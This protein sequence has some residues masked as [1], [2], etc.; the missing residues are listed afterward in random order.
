MIVRIAIVVAIV[1]VLMIGW[2][3]ITASRRLRPSVAS[4]KVSPA[5]LG[6]ATIPDAILFSTPYCVPCSRIIA[7]IDGSGVDL[8][9]VS[10]DRRL[11]L[12]RVHEI[13]TSPT[14]LILD[15]DGHIDTRLVGTDAE[16]WAIDVR[17]RGQAADRDK[18]STTALS[19]RSTESLGQAK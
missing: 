11:E 12:V 17:R 6:R 2:M 4:V 18:R 8:A 15:I 5:A 10:I 1:A 14:V 3:L 19:D 7:K 13:R 9:T 16:Q